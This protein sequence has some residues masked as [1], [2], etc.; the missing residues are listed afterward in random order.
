MGGWGWG[1]SFLHGSLW[2][3]PT[4]GTDM[5]RS[6]TTLKWGQLDKVKYSIEKK[7]WS[8]ALQILQ[9]H[10]QKAKQRQLKSHRKNHVEYA[11]LHFSSITHQDTF[12][13]NG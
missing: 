8:V 7:I 9:L 10:L 12:I 2:T 1:P 4:Y 11:H 5:V 13:C 3:I 6:Y